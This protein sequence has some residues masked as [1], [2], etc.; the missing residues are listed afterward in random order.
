MLSCICVV[1]KARAARGFFAGRRS[2]RG[3]VVSGTKGRYEVSEVGSGVGR[4]F[5]LKGDTDD[6]TGGLFQPEMRKIPSGYH[7][8]P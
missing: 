5:L 8:Y 6:E 2:Q 3:G 7:N 1:V 4:I